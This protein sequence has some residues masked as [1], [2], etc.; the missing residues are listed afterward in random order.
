MKQSDGFQTSSWPLE[1]WNLESLTLAAYYFNPDLDVARANA[2]LA[3]AVIKTAAMKPNPSVSIGPGFQ[4]PAEAQFIMG[5]NFSLPIE[6]AGK[7]GYRV[8]ASEHS[9]TASR[10]QLGQV[11]WTVR[12]RVRVTLVDHIFA[13]KSVES[14]R[15]E[16]ALRGEYVQRIEARFRAG[17]IPLPDVTTARIDLFT[18]RQT[19]STTQGQVETTEAALAA[20]VGVPIS[21]LHGKTF[22]LSSA[23]QPPQPDALP[24]KSIRADAVQNRLDVRRALE[25]YEASQS[26]LQLQV[27]QQYP[28]INLGPAYSYEEATN[29]ISLSLSSVL[30]IRNQNQG[31]IAEAEAQRKLAGAQLLAVQSGVIA[32][33]DKA[34]AQYT[35]SYTTLDG[36][37]NAIR[38]LHQQEQSAKRLLQAG[39]TEQI[40]AVAA[41]LQTAVAERARL[42]ALHQT[43]L[44]LGLIEDALQRPVDLGAALNLPKQA[45]R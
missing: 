14:L 43:Q 29:L 32:D 10:L 2:A 3:D 21:A 24:Q 28:D 37:T 8:A 17:E 13:L 23:D 12:S 35:A 25:Q 45:P 1:A 9:S 33:T 30:P 38:L 20:A 22:L 42:D 44:S 36:A 18:L 31:P 41:Q 15:K 5:F 7:R 19:L 6:T 4:G 11:A 39:E 27:A 16:V 26:A 40:T 34:L